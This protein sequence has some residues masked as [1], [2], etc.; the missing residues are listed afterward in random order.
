MKKYLQ[1]KIN[2]SAVTSVNTNS[3]LLVSMSFF[4]IINILCLMYQI[5][6]NTLNTLNVDIHVYTFSQN[7]FLGGL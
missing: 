4:F 6:S 7:N 5:K 3:Y 1:Y 2:A